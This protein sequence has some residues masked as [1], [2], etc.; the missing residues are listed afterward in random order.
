MLGLLGLVAQTTDPDLCLKAF[1][2]HKM[3]ITSFPRLF[4]YLM[5]GHESEAEGRRISVV[6]EKIKL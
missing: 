5:I 1:Q 3:I 2:Q 4:F 6:Q